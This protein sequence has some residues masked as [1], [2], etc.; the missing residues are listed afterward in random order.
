MTYGEHYITYGVSRPYARCDMIHGPGSAIRESSLSRFKL[1]QLLTGIVFDKH[2]GVSLAANQEPRMLGILI[3]PLGTY[4]AQSGNWQQG[5]TQFLVN[6]QGEAYPWPPSG[7]SPVRSTTTSQPLQNKINE[8]LDLG[9][10]P[11]IQQLNDVHGPRRQCVIAENLHQPTRFDVRSEQDIRL[12][13]NPQ[14]LPGR[15]SQGFAIIGPQCAPHSSRRAAREFPRVLRA[16]AVEREAV[17]MGQVTWRLG[18][19]SLGKIG[20]CRAYATATTRARNCH[21]A[22][23]HV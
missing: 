22:T 8:R 21:R 5:N 1:M 13:D 14:P 19:S 23:R 15:D 10:Q 12:L 6:A 9:R 4:A 11:P 7:A 18:S 20:R 17:M 2:V 3:T 16:P